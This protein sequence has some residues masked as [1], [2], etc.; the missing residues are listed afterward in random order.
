MRVG[1]VVL[2][3]GFYDSVHGVCVV[4]I[5]LWQFY[6]KVCVSIGGRFYQGLGIRNVTCVRIVASIGVNT[7]DCIA[8]L[9]NNKQTGETKS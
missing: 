8:G 9:T 3:V 2:R 4:L 1:V 5:R 7:F 6:Y